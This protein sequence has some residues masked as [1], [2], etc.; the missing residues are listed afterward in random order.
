MVTKSGR[1]SQRYAGW[2]TDSQGSVSAGWQGCIDEVDQTPSSKAISD[3]KLIS[4]SVG[5]QRIDDLRECVYCR[6]HNLQQVRSNPCIS[7]PGVDN[8]TPTAGIPSS[9]SFPRFW[10]HGLSGAVVH[11]IHLWRSFN[12]FHTAITSSQKWM[13]VVSFC[14]TS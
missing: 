2:M 11:F 6:I 3:V 1:E 12:E 5:G 14:R 8:A 13:V 4:I 7:T 10:S 9:N